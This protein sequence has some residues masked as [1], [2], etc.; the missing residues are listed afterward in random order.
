MPA[1]Q[2]TV[3]NTADLTGY[4]ASGETSL[5]FSTQAEAYQHQQSL[6]RRN[7]ALAGQI[8]V[9]SDYELAA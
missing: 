9:V 8:Q 5:T 2:Y 4:A 7:P 3:A 1:E 6:I